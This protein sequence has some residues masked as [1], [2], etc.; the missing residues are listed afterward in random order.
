[1]RWHGIRALG[2]IRDLRALPVL[3]RALADA[4]QCVAWMAAK[5]LVPFGRQ[6]VG[7]V[8]RLLMSAPVTQWLVETSS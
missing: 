1:M 4:D 3:V 2:K 6:S 5:G 8:L 7:P